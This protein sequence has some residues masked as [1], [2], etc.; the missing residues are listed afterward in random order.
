MDKIK[1]TITSTYES[2]KNFFIELKTGKLP[3][4][5]T[6]NVMPQDKTEQET[7]SEKKNLSPEAIKLL[8][9][10][11]MNKVKENKEEFAE[12][13]V[14]VANEVKTRPEWLL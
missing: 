12:K 4:K 13:L 6:E 11:L 14:R 10:P 9:Q 2:V 3:E 7:N 1:D 8:K 5:K